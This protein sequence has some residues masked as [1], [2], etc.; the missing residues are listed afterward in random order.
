MLALIAFFFVQYAVIC[1]SADLELESI[2][3]AIEHEQKQQI[4]CLSSLHC[5]RYACS[6]SRVVH[7]GDVVF[8]GSEVEIQG[9]HLF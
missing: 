3:A 6:F 1:V 7:A 9:R 8:T 2:I 4:L 5:K